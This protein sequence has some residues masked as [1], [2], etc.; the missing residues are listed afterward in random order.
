VES[1][2]TLGKEW[3]DAFVFFKHEESGE[4]PKLAEQFRALF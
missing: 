1:V 3:K 2:K 4:G